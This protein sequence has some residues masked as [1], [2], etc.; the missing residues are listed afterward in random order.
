VY[1]DSAYDY[2]TQIQES[3]GEMTSTISHNF[4]SFAANN[5]KVNIISYARTLYPLIIL[6]YL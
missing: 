6:N 3:L 1:A 4:T 5:L 2:P